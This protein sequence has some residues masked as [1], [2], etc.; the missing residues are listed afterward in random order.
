LAAF[1]LIESWEPSLLA[2]DWVFQGVVGG[3]SLVVGYAVGALLTRFANLLR[4]RWGWGLGPLDERTDLRVR[5]IV[6]VVLVALLARSASKEVAEHR[7]TWDRLGYEPGS[8]WAVYGGS[9]AVTGVVAV[10][11]FLLGWAFRLLQR[12]LS[13]LGRRWLPAW[14]AGSLAFVVLAW[15]V[16]ASLN[17]YVLER[18]LDGANT[19][20][21]SADLDTDDAPARPDSL[22]RSGGSRSEVK[23]NEAGRE[24]RRFLS[25]GPDAATIAELAPDATTEPVR[26][27]VG[28]ASAEDVASRVELAMAELERYGAFDRAALLVV[29]PTGTGWINEQVVQPVEYFFGGDTATVAVQYSHLPSPLAFMAEAEAASDTGTALVDAVRARL[30]EIP[31]GSRPALL[32]AGESLGS[33]GGGHAFATLDEL[34]AQTDGSLWVGPPET[35]HL[36]REAERIRRPDSLQIKPVVGGGEDV[37]FANRASDLSGTSPRTVFLQQGDDPIVWWDW[38]LAFSEP[39]WL[40]E[41]LDPSVNPAMSWTPVTT[42]LNLAMDMGVSNDFD[43][44]HGHLYGTQPLT[45]WRAMLEPAAWDDERTEELRDRLSAVTR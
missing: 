27:Y 40:E 14:I 4:R 13:R 37:V 12:R 41:P 1:L 15:A 24:G 30:G 42:F 31:E 5:G 25:R 20:F 7:W 26:V 16:L 11:F 21:A 43:E 34:L 35:M 9:I 8:L 22:V 19:S 32:V 23:W 28:R 45:A 6:G 17:S 18:S 39:D 2:R 10:L 29:V 36:R 44:D 33:F 38:G 3:I